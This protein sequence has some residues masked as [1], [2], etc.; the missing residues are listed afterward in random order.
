L[1]GVTGGVA[2]LLVVSAMTMRPFKTSYLLW[3]SLS[4]ALFLFYFYGIE[5]VIAAFS[6]KLR[7]DDLLSFEFIGPVVFSVVMGWLAQCAIVIIYSWIRERAKA[8][9]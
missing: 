8:K 6:G 9:H 3:C 4:L 7:I 1:A 5:A 2:Q